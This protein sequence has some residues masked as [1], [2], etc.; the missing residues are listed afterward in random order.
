MVCKCTGAV[1]PESCFGQGVPETSKS[2]GD[3]PLTY[4][5]ICISIYVS[6]NMELTGDQ[7]EGFG[8]IFQRPVG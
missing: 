1:R 3:M 4:S 7:D 8:K 6:T 5:D 2:R